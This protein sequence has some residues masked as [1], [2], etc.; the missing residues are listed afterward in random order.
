MDTCV[1]L[2]GAGDHWGPLG[3]TGDHGGPSGSIDRGP[4]GPWGSARG[5]PAGTRA[6]MSPG[7]SPSLSPPVR[8]VFW[9]WAH[10]PTYGQEE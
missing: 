10:A 7:G 8:S 4:W 2:G 1:A 6:R 3:T 5:H 9:F